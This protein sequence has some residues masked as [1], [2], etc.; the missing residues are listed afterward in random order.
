MVS[1]TDPVWNIF[2]RSCRWPQMIQITEMVLMLSMQ[3]ITDGDSFISNTFSKFFWS[4]K[5]CKN[6][7]GLQLNF[8][9]KTSWRIHTTVESTDKTTKKLK[10]C[11][12][13][14]SLRIQIDLTL[15][16]SQE[17][18]RKPSSLKHWWD[19]M[20]KFNEAKNRQLFIQ[21]NERNTWTNGA[22]FRNVFCLFSAK[23]GS[24]SWQNSYLF[25]RLSEKN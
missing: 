21:V 8:V 18:Y 6:F 25:L 17:E 15:P 2:S 11:V 13:V 4:E 14:E 1:R 23:R 9:T 24:G 22:K 12:N 3:F 5:P 20:E 10:S 19:K 7:E 16:K